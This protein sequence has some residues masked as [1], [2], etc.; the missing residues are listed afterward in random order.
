[1]LSKFGKEN[2]ALQKGAAS[3]KTNPRRHMETAKIINGS[4]EQHMDDNDDHAD[5]GDNVEVPWVRLIHFYLDSLI[6]KDAADRQI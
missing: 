2:K 1:M 6:L 4:E 5:N 3:R